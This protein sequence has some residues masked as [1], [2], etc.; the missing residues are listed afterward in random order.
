MEAIPVKATMMGADTV[1]SR[2][3]QKHC[4]GALLCDPTVLNE[5]SNLVP[6]FRWFEGNSQVKFRFCELLDA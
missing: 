2:L 5:V 4:L 3:G 1:A 6:W